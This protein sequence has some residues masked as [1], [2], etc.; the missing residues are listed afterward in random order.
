MSPENLSCM[1]L[2]GVRRCSL[3]GQ[4]RVRQSSKGSSFL[5]GGGGG[6]VVWGGVG[7][8]FRGNQWISVNSR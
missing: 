6:W 8:G 1:V 5:G 4:L 2:K 7:K 3:T